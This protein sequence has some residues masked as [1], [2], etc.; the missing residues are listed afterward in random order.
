M[1]SVLSAEKFSFVFA[2][3]CSVVRSVSYTHLAELEA[4]CKELDEK[5]TWLLHNSRKMDNYLELEPFSNCL[6]YTSN[7][8]YWLCATIIVMFMLPFVEAQLASECSGM[9]LCLSLIHIY[10]TIGLLLC[11]GKDE[12]VALYALTG[13]DLSL[14]HI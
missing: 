11:K 13:Y 6:L 1:E 9:V 12:V 8:I 4:S 10:K 14:I 3:F 2:S 7:Y 5:V